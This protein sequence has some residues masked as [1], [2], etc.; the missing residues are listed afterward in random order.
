VKSETFT[1]LRDR[2]S[3]RQHQDLHLHPLSGE[4]EWVFKGQNRKTEMYSALKAD[5]EVPDDP[6]TALNRPLLDKILATPGKIYVAGQ[7]SAKGK[8][9]VKQNDRLNHAA[10][11]RCRPPRSPG[12]PPCTHRLGLTALT[13]RF[14]ISWRTWGG[15]ALLMWFC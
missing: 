2:S 13:S 3:A 15:G 12:S 14:G 10:Q 6:A 7:V 9:V 1:S 5:V 11:T 8:L 4:V